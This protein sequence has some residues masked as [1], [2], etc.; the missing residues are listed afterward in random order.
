MTGRVEVCSIFFKRELAPDKRV[1]PRDTVVLLVVPA[2]L[3]EPDRRDGGTGVCAYV[4]PRHTRGSLMM[5][6]RPLYISINIH[7]SEYVDK[8]GRKMS[9]VHI[10]TLS[11]MST[12]IHC[13][14]PAPLRALAI[15]LAM[16]LGQRALLRIATSNLHG[17]PVLDGPL[18]VHSY[19]F[20]H[21]WRWYGE[22]LAD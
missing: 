9:Q 13:A 16:D 15:L 10:N 14:V 12:I 2:G 21:L 18:R 22:N 3:T 1:D 8:S 6:K 7:R 5:F 17:G 19:F 4:L 11:R 20:V